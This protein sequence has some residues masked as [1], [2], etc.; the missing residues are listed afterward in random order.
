MSFDYFDDEFLEKIPS[1]APDLMFAEESANQQKNDQKTRLAEETKKTEET[2]LEDAELEITVEQ[3]EVLVDVDD[4][5]PNTPKLESPIEST[6][7]SNESI[8]TEPSSNET[9]SLS[10]VDKE[11]L[12]N[13]IIDDHAYALPF[14]PDKLEDEISCTTSVLKLHPKDLPAKKKYQ[15]KSSN[16]N[17]IDIVSVDK[18][19]EMLVRFVI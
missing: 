5:Q 19:E 10:T 16:D 18:P 13:F 12:L 17:D 7:I 11:S 1:I 14:G 2:I 8:S 6:T 9:I 15:G 3:G 4:S